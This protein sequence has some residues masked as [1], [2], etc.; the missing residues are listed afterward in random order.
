MKRNRQEDSYVENEAGREPALLGMMAN[1]PNMSMCAQ[2]VMGITGGPCV[3]D[4]L[5]QNRREGIA[6]CT[7]SVLKTLCYDLVYDSMIDCLSFEYCTV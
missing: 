4:H 7:C 6:K 3:V 2:D 5:K 1:A